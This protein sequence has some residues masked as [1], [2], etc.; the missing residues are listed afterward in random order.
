MRVTLHFDYI[1]QS[2]QQQWKHCLNPKPTFTHT[3][4]DTHTDT[5]TYTHAPTHAHTHTHTHTHTQH[6]CSTPQNPLPLR[7]STSVCVGLI[8]TSSLLP[9]LN[10]RGLYVLPTF[11]K[12]TNLPKNAVSTKLNTS[13]PT[14]ISSKQRCKYSLLHKTYHTK[15]LPQWEAKIPWEFSVLQTALQTVGKESV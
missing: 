6:P 10:I 9:K 14:I 13:L 11:G 12:C 8:S 5:D 3:C 1:H 2:I 7:H 4:T 15:C